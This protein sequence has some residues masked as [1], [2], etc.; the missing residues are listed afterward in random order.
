M[1]QV[2]RC[3]QCFSANPQRLA[4]REGVIEGLVDGVSEDGEAAHFAAGAGIEATLNGCRGGYGFRLIWR[5]SMKGSG[6]TLRGYFR[7]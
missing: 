1:G 4:D 3:H 6:R 2:R 7:R 5:R